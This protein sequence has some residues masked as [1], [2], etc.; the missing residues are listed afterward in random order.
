MAKAASEITKANGFASTLTVHPLCSTELTVP[1]HLPQK[2]NVLVHEILGSGIFEENVIP[3]I[4]DARKR[5]LEEDVVIIPKAGWFKHTHL[6]GDRYFCF[7]SVI[8]L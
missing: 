4:C 5:L 2:A 6:F 8:C 7:T 3:V 1:N